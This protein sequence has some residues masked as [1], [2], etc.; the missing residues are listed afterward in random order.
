MSAF[1]GIVLAFTPL[2]GSTADPELILGKREMPFYQS[3]KSEQRK[4]H[5]LFGRLAAKHALIYLSQGADNKISVQ[6]FQ[7]MEILPDLMGRPIFQDPESA[8]VQISISLVLDLH[9]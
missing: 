7:N 3:F 4:K 9:S 8:Q 6:D 2:S 1:D 5:F